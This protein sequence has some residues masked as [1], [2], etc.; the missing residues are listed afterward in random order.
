MALHHAK[1]GEVVN[2]APM[3]PRLREGKSAAIIKGDHF[4]T[5]RLIVHAGTQIPQHQVAGEITL[6]CL[7][8]HVELGID[9]EP[10]ALKS[11][12]WVYLEAGAPHS[13][14]AIVDSCVLLTVF[15]ERHSGQA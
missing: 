11:N 9:P 13:V 1:P 8:G 4:E 14:R 6:H 10:I 5:I 3:G 7:E 12:E 2:L 15:L